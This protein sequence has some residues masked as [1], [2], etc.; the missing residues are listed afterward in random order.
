MKY[1]IVCVLLFF[2]LLCFGQV[3]KDPYISP[4]IS[5]GYCFS[6]HG[7]S[8]GLDCDIGL[9]KSY[10]GPKQ[11]NYGFS[12]SRYWTIVK[13]RS[14]RQI[15]RHSTLDFMIETEN[16]DIKAGFGTAFNPWGYGNRNR[17]KVNGFNTDISYT[18]NEYT[19]PWIGL[20]G[21]FYKRRKWR[22][23]DAPYITLYSKYKYDFGRSGLKH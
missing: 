8:F 4:G 9:Y 15:H 20:K 21:F 16:V 2:G 17:C 23:H 12:I 3:E 18:N 19:K 6:T 5:L 10:E 11:V 13:K 1:L 14:I 22:W 7:M